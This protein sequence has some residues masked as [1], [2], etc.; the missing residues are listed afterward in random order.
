MRFLI[1][2]VVVLAIVAGVGIYMGW[3]RVG[4]DKSSDKPN[5][6]I[7]VDK[8]K[9]KEDKD[10][11]VEKAQDLGHRAADKVDTAIDRNRAPATQPAQ[12]P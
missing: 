7:T 9:I 8:D 6:T 12:Q 4:S 3:F 1:K 2:L 11:A 10:K 5:L